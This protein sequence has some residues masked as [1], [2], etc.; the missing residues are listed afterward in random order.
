MQKSQPA[1]KKKTQYV[2]TYGE[3][4]TAAAARDTLS[5]IHFPF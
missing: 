1:F 5:F 4:D 2:P 3:F